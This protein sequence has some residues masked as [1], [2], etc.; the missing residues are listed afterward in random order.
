MTKGLPWTRMR[1]F[2]SVKPEDFAERCLESRNA[3]DSA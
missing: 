2:A 1:A 3:P